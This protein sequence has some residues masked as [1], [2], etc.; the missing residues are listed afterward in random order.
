MTDSCFSFKLPQLNNLSLRRVNSRN[1]L[2]QTTPDNPYCVVIDF[3]A[4]TEKE[5]GKLDTINEKK[6]NNK[7]YRIHQNPPHTFEYCSSILNN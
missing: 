2:Q 3:S 1:S 6:Y 7:N 5:C 4:I